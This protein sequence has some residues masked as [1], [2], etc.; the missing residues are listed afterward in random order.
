MYETLV[1]KEEMISS[2]DLGD[3]FRIKA[4]SRD[5]NYEKYFD[6]GSKVTNFEEYNSNNTK[7]LTKEELVKLLTKEGF[8]N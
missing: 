1:S 7:L 8:S 4:D 5:L 2:E 3:Y 6:S